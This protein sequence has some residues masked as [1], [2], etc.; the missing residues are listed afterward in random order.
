MKLTQLHTGNKNV[1]LSDLYSHTISCLI[2]GGFTPDQTKAVSEMLVEL[3][4]I[5]PAIRGIPVAGRTQIYRTILKEMKE[6]IYPVHPLGW[7]AM[8]HFFKEIGIDTIEMMVTINTSKELRKE[9][10]SSIL[11]RLIWN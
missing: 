6:D 11:Y 4:W 2:K 7:S 8:C 3:D 5:E 1:L 9:V 10:E